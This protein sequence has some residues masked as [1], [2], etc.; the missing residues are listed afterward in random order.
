MA[1]ECVSLTRMKRDQNRRGIF[2]STSSPLISPLWF[3]KLT[4]V[5]WLWQS[6]KNGRTCAKAQLWHPSLGAFTAS[7]GWEI[8]FIVTTVWCICVDCEVLYLHTNLA[9]LVHL[10]SGRACDTGRHFNH[11]PK[12]VVFFTPHA[13]SYSSS[14]CFFF[15][16]FCL[17]K[18]CFHVN[19]IESISFAN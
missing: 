3:R 10:R 5:S 12:V 6:I 15:P 14:F 8:A 18:F 9:W 17:I 19:I 16:R 11:V 1:W 2:M 4:R 7:A 13:H